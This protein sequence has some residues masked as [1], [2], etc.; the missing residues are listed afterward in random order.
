MRLDIRFDRLHG[1]HHVVML[2]QSR[3]KAAA[4]QNP[5]IYIYVHIYVSL[6]MSKSMYMYM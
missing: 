2:P 4:G 6:V 3:E 5:D 1:L